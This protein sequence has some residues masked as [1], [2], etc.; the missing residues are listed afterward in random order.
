MSWHIIRVFLLS[1]FALFFSALAMSCLDGQDTEAT[2][3]RLVVAESR[4]IDA[5]LSEPTSRQNKSSDSAPATQSQHSGSA[6]AILH[7]VRW[8]ISQRYN[9]HDG[10][11]DRLDL[12]PPWYQVSD[13][14]LLQRLAQ[15]PRYLAYQD[16]RPS[17]RLSGWKETN[18]MYV[19]LNSHYFS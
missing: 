13:A 9:V 10:D 17:Y 19:A 8:H 12:A 7:S 4:L 5:V 16:F 15:S 18:A 2:A 3:K 14:R 6:V 1:F 11:S